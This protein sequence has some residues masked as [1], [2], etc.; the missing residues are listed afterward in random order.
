MVSQKIIDHGYA[1]IVKEI[2]K[3][4][5]LY[6]KV[7]FPEAGAAGYPSHH[8]IGAQPAGDMSEV[9]KVAAVQ[10]FGAPSRNIPERSFVRTSFDNN[11][12]ALQAFKAAQWKLIIEG[13]QTAE[14]GIRKIGEWM[15]AK[16]KRQI[17][18]GSY[19]PLKPA[20]IAR[21]KSSRPLIDTAQMINSIQQEVFTK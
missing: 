20:T 13:K 17:R 10:E 1:A 12:G 21:K 4:G 5:H 2:E 8:S 15:I 14:Q 7:G 18:D 11:Y 19:V 3:M 9:I 6:T 16:M